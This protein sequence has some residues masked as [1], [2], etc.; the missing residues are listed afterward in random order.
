MTIRTE[1]LALDDAQPADAV[2][3]IDVL[4]AFTTVPWALHSGAARI[5]AVDTLDRARE[6]RDTHLPDALLAGEVHGETPPGF[7]LGNSPTEIQRTD[8]RGRTII[9]RTTAG[10][11]GLARTAGSPLVLAASFVN[12]QATADA[13]VA[14]SAV[15]VAFIITGA[16]HG[17]D[18]DEDLACAEL[19]A[20]RLNGQAPDPAPFLARIA[21]S[22]AGQAFATDGAE[23]APPEDMECAR[24]LDRFHF[25]VVAEPRQELGAIE[26]RVDR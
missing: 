12:A 10:T 13:L 20:A 19:I 5:L 6:I 25:A 2:V 1:F 21:Q 26:V 18:G 24:E 22:D 15:E 8:V 4:R 3:V 7:D 16:S 14:S 11:Q 9:H 23:W 17:R